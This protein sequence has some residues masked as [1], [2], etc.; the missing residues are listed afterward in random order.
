MISAMGATPYGIK[1]IFVDDGSTDDAAAI[2]KELAL[3]DPRLT[4]VQLRRNF[5]QSPAM[6]AG[7]D[8]GPW[9][10]FGNNRQR[11]AE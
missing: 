7:I 6:S 5:G 10:D 8:F 3:T 4:L 9:P 1:L 2:A 11:P